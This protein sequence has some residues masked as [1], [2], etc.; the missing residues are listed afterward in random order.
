MDSRELLESEVVEWVVSR[1]G[2][3]SKSGPPGWVVEMAKGGEVD[4]VLK[5][6]LVGGGVGLVPKYI[7]SK[8]EE[9]WNIRQR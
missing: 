9:L 8:A 3:S 1:G 4:S 2:T 6:I 7:Y 5:W